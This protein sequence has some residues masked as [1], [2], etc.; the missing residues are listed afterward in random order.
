MSHSE[1]DNAERL[2]NGEERTVTD[3]VQNTEFLSSSTAP[4]CYPDLS[5]L[6]KS[7]DPVH[8]VSQQLCSRREIPVSISGQT[9]IEDLPLMTPLFPP[10]FSKIRQRTS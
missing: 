10:P 7:I 9:W 4:D 3:Q 1:V 2:G 5:D 8:S 6:P